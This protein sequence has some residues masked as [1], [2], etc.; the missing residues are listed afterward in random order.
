MPIF[1]S[2]LT[3]DLKRSFNLNYDKIK[4]Q[5]S[6][7]G[8]ANK[9]VKTRHFS[10]VD[11]LLPFQIDDFI[12]ELRPIQNHFRVNFSVGY[13][14]RKEMEICY[15]YHSANNSCLLAA[16]LRVNEESDIEAFRA[17]FEEGSWLYID[18]H[19]N[20][21]PQIQNQLSSFFVT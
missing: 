14:L 18:S 5:S 8:P 10:Y 19:K 2:L 16:A 20:L 13:M 4:A 7:Y 15:F 12:A 3:A 1:S 6:S 17:K 21:R 9:V 11:E